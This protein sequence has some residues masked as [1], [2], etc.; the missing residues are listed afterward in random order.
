M[1]SVP[2]WENYDLTGHMVWS[3]M[4]D[5]QSWLPG[6]GAQGW[7]LKNDEEFSGQL[8][9]WG[10]RI[11]SRDTSACRGAEVWDDRTWWGSENLAGVTGSGRQGILNLQVTYSSLSF[12]GAS[13]NLDN[14]KTCSFGFTSKSPLLGSSWSCW[15]RW[16]GATYHHPGGTSGR[17]ACCSLCGQCPEGTDCVPARAGE[18]QTA[19]WASTKGSNSNFKGGGHWLCLASLLRL[20]RCAS[21]FKYHIISFDSLTHPKGK[22]LCFLLL[23][24]TQPYKVS[25][26]LPWATTCPLV[27]TQSCF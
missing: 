10:K 7:D 4:R 18:S 5:W 12:V 26:G 15:G 13:N 14:C 6:R 25:P 17:P 2:G 21:H 27:L 19:S 23:G 9:R 16:L 20:I 24:E 3:T 22:I 1:G 8:Q 11:L